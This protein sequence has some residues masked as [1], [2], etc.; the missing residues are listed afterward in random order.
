[1]KRFLVLLIMAVFL[2][3][4][5]DPKIDTSTEDSQ[6]KSIEKVRNALSEQKR[7]E[8]DDAMKI[9]VFSKVNLF[10]P[11]E[12]EYTMKNA[13]TSLNGKNGNEVIAEGKRIKEEQTE[14]EKERAAKE[15]EGVL[16]AIKDLE[17]K[18][19]LAESA[20][21]ELAKFKIV[22][23]RF[24]KRDHK[25]YMGRIVGK[26]PVIELKVKN[27]TSYPVS[28]AHF[29]G[30]LNSPGRSVPWVKESFMY[31]IRGGLEKG[32]E[33]TW[34]LLPE[35]YGIWG[36]TKIPDDAILTVKTVKLD[37]SDDKVLFDSKGFTESEEESL[38][39]KKMELAKIDALLQGAKK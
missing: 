39:T 11:K 2:S 18:K 1:M 13:I 12:S 34:T 9:I 22:S 32:E 35:Q 26:E 24:Y 27:E 19:A 36:T 21:A 16:K 23:A 33:S 25:D 10:N 8:F 30:A 17:S 38:K 31:H 7:T 3:G 29:D 14:K 20:K 6:K 4:C 37:G 5:A 28:W 15:R